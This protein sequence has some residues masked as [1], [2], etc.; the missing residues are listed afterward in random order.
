MWTKIA[1]ING[2]RIEKNSQED[3]F[4]LYVDDI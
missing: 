4:H 1:R 2:K 3:D